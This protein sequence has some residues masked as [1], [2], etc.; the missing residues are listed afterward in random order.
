MKLNLLLSVVLTVA[1]WG[2]TDSSGANKSRNIKLV[3]LEHSEIWSKGNVDLLDTV[4]AENVIGHFPAGIVQGHAGIR[5]RI[6]AHRTAFPDWTEVIDDVI[7]EGDRVVTRFTSR[8]TNLGE[9]LGNPATGNHVEISEVCVHR[10]AEGKIVE[11]WVYPD[12]RSM[13]QQLSS[14]TK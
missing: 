1:A 5:A 11:I 9:F 6:K 3:E 2:C 10:I 4:Y 14:G 13:Q 12:F 8:G 7:V